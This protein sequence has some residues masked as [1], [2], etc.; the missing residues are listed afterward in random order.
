LGTIVLFACSFFNIFPALARESRAGDFVTKV[1]FGLTG[2]S[3]GGYT[4]LTEFGEYCAER[5]D[6]SV[7]VQGASHGKT[8]RGLDVVFYSV[9]RGDQRAGGN[10]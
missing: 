5:E 7:S 6:E 3:C 10:T 2:I 9:E 4:A 1:K 8:D